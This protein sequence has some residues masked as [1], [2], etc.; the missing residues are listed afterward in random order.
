MCLCAF[1]GKEETLTFMLKN[2]A[3]TSLQRT[4]F[5]MFSVWRVHWERLWE[6]IHQLNITPQL[7]S[8]KILYPELHRSALF[9]WEGFCFHNIETHSIMERNREVDGWEKHSYK[10]LFV[11][12]LSFG[13]WDCPHWVRL[14]IEFYWRNI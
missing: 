8:L 14:I 12:N 5:F 10:R 2:F 6:K 3:Q 9:W 11:W 1:W 13:N 7:K 4:E